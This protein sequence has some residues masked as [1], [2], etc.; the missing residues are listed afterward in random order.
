MRTT[1][2]QAVPATKRNY[3]VIAR[4]NGFIT[5]MWG[6]GTVTTHSI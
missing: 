3:R 2:V 4:G 1:T 6:D 5:V